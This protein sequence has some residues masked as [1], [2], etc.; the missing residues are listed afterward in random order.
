MVE[1]PE[2]MYAEP[3][4]ILRT[5]LELID[6]DRPVRTLMVTSAVEGEGKSTTVAN[7]AVSA[8]LAGR[9]VILVD[10][11]FRHPSLGTFFPDTGS[12][13][14][15]DVTLG[16]VSLG[17]ALSPVVLGGNRAG[18]DADSGG[19]SS[20]SGN[21]TLG[22]ATT[23]RVL[24]TGNLPPNPGEF[25]GSAAVERVLADLADRADLVL[26]D[27]AP[28]LG[29][30]DALTLASKVEGLIL[31]TRLNRLRRPMVSELERAL[32]GSRARPLGIVVTG[33]SED[34]AYGYAYGYAY[35]EGSVGAAAGQ[36]D[37]VPPARE[38]QS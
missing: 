36:V 25:V 18:S 22:R 9:E 38:H 19:L 37:P 15:T 31:V 26:I 35:G 16:H 13:G 10:L 14:M 2:T 33:V 23:L 11:D 7:L 3:F 8:A 28:M 32:H 20:A 29:I 4:R 27:S 6:P 30:G 21:G 1:G 12:L 17:E 34:A 5:N 24:P